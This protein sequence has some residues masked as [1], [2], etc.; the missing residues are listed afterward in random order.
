[1]SGPTKAMAAAASEQKF[2][3]YEA[4]RAKLGIKQTEHFAAT[5][6][7][8][9]KS[10]AKASATAIRARLEELKARREAGV[11]E[12][13]RELAYKL[14]QEDACI[15]AEL[16]SLEETPEERR[17]KLAARARA[18]ADRREAER[19]AL[20]Q[21]LYSQ[22][23]AESCDV[24]R[25]TQSKRMLLRTL[26]E[27]SAQIEQKMSTKIMEEEEKRMYYEMN[28]QERLKAEQ[29]YMDDKRRQREARE[30]TNKVLDEQIRIVN[31]QK[32][33]AEGQRQQ[34][35]RESRALWVQLEAEAWAE[36]EQERENMRKLASDLSEFN[37]MKQSELSEKERAERELDLKIL[38][39]ALGR[40]AEVEAAESAL[41]RERMLK[42]QAYRAQL[43][44]MMAH[45]AE[46]E[47]ERDAM[48]QG[49]ANQQQAKRDAELAAR[50]AARARLMA[51]VDAIRQQQILEKQLRRQ[52]ELESSLLK[53][54]HQLAAE[55]KYQRDASE[56]ERLAKKKALIQRLELQTQMV[57]K[58]HMQAAA[59]VDKLAQLENA[60]TNEAMYMTQVKSTLDSSV[61]PAWHGR[62]KV[63]WY[64]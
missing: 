49:V 51:E 16:L 5:V 19:Q 14:A 4:A 54:G 24:L 27:R 7:W 62:K 18:L 46:D 13:R 55:E 64:Y 31:S 59:E 25:T 32:A 61:P 26:D 41:R 20:A 50:D 36:E 9:V 2:R 48:I 52:G 15:R 60:K 10:G 3:Q 33:E 45:E 34:E 29:R 39:E 43:A 22:A 23:F 53:D 38:Q 30:A 1:M 8:S 58:A 57:A 37:R 47:A 21:S 12:R 56:S 35:I 63:E 17:A 11:D 42:A 6:D 44:K 40:E 28:E